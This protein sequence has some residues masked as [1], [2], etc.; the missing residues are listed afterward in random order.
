MIIQNEHM[1]ARTKD[2]SRSK[3]SRLLQ[4]LDHEHEHIEVFSHL[5]THTLSLQSELC[6]ANHI[7]ASA[8]APYLEADGSTRTL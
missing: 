3:A 2:G 1:S 6:P 4:G 5:D 7:P 8:L